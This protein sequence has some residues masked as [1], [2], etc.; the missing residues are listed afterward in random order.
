[1]GGSLINLQSLD[2]SFNQLRSVEPDLLKLVNLKALYLHG[3]C[4]QSMSSVERLRKL[5]KL[6]SLTLNGNPVESNKGYRPHVI[7]ALTPN[8]LRK[9][10][11]STITNEE[12]AG[13]AAWYK[14]H[15]QRLKE[16]KERMDDMRAANMD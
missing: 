12:I 1:M 7:A 3:N 15:L 10:D 13:A 8:G 4:I 16:H 5:P 14:G 2:I 11:H 6:M 9:L